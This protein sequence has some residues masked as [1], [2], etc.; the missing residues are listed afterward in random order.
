MS[1]LVDFSQPS[2]WSEFARRKTERSL[3][4]FSD[5]I[6]PEHSFCSVNRVQ[7]HVLEVSDIDILLVYHRINVCSSIAA[8][9]GIPS[10]TSRAAK[11]ER[12]G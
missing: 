8:R 1:D 11:T 3:S 4:F 7:S 5:S 2:L 10:P 9:Q 6:D 12:E